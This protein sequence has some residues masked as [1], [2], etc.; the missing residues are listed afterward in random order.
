MAMRPPSDLRM[1]T[2]VTLGRASPHGSLNGGRR[3]SLGFTLV[4]LLVVFA[5]LAMLVALVPLAFGRLREAAQ[6]RDS[7]RSMVTDMRSART[8]AISLGTDV[9]FI[10]NTA[11]RSYG[12]EG[13]ATH[14]LPEPLVMR[15]TVANQEIAAGRFASIRFLPGGG[16]TGGS[17]DI[18]RPSG[19]GV[20]LRVDWLF[21][22]VEQEGIGS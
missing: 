2:S 13:G 7:V 6:Y 8:R 20:R 18:V 22:R 1:P 9:R 10:V 21:G 4:E 3:R 19:S 12:V 15:A 14:R 11:A 5:I 16:A 17:I